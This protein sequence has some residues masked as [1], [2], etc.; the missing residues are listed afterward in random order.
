MIQKGSS[1]VYQTYLHPFLTKNEADIDAGLTA[2]QANI[3]NFLQAQVIKVWETLWRLMT[4]AAPAGQQATPGTSSNTQPPASSAPNPFTLAKGLWDTYGTSV[5]QSVQNFAP[6]TGAN[7]ASSE[8]PHLSP[9]SSSHS[10]PGTPSFP[11][12]Q[13]H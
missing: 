8:R 11:E 6:A 2:A 12:P 7:P 1:W 3:L 9:A 4:G 5:M 13:H 10:K